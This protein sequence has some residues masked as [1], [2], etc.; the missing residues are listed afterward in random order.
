MTK[1]TNNPFFH[2]IK[3]QCSDKPID[4]KFVLKECKRFSHYYA[5]E[6]MIFKPKHIIAAEYSDLNG[7]EQ[8]FL[9]KHYY[10]LNPNDVLKDEYKNLKN[11]NRLKYNIL[12]RRIL[13]I[14]HKMKRIKLED[15]KIGF[16]PIRSSSVQIK[17]KH[18]YFFTYVVVNNIAI[19]TLQPDKN[20][21]DIP[22]NRT[23]ENV[24]VCLTSIKLTNKRKNFLVENIK[25]YVT[26]NGDLC[27]RLTKIPVIKVSDYSDVLIKDNKIKQTIF[28]VDYLRYANGLE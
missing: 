25:E 21:H 17:K 23:S 24:F 15:D 14:F 13:D 1:K 4:I 28:L 22:I 2:M 19:V 10:S 5:L 7:I 3:G 12:V 9:L 27:P 26:G 18:V 20:E 8:D 16:R 6:K 11:K